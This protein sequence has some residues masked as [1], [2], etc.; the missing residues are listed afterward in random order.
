MAKD[1][2]HKM[3]F[4][5]LEVV[6]DEVTADT[7]TATSAVI[8]GNTLSGTELGFLDG[9]SAGTASAS[10]AVVLGSSKEI[11]TI[12]TATIT[13]LVTSD[14]AMTVSS[15]TVGNVEPFNLDTTLTG[16]GATGGRAK[17]TLTTDVAL[18]GW[19]NALKAQ[20][21]YD[22]GGRTTGLGSAFCAEM[23]LSAG[24]SA[25]NYALFE[26]EL[27]LATGAL[28]GTATSLFYLSIN[29]DD[30]A[31]FD[32]NGYLLNIQGVTGSENKFFDNAA[33]I[34]NVDEIT[35]G[36]RI[37]IGSSDYYILLASAA[38]IAD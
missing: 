2:S 5:G 20:V 35:G 4:D 36:L 29:G 24:T 13:N 21:T 33:E 26:G 9:V 19:S 28:T 25:G 6:A 17:F 15:A 1:K 14:V 31:T 10:K 11:A 16:V 27:N 37:K 38:D 8:G 30:A 22:D 23:T 34:G 12:T 7:V 3:D 32:T 18:G